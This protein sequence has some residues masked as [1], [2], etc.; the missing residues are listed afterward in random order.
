MAFT[1]ELDLC[2]TAGTHVRLG[3]S[4][5]KK[6]NRQHQG[7]PPK[8]MDT[9]KFSGKI[10]PQNGEEMVLE[11]TQEA[12]NSNAWRARGGELKAIILL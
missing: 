7:T 9:W 6:I 8:E 4:K 10:K 11:E 3:V 1:S 5:E 12:Q 2:T